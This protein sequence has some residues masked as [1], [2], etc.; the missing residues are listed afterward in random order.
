MAA[1]N[2]CFS[3]R[4]RELRESS[5]ISKRN[6]AQQTGVDPSYVA[7]MESSG[8]VPKKEKIL[9]M[10]SVLGLSH[11]DT[12]TLLVSAGYTPHYMPLDVILK[13]LKNYHSKEKSAAKL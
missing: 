11:H 7:L 2:F 4:L 9:S 6:L 5:S 10:S 1:G 13:S 12:D 8:F 3:N